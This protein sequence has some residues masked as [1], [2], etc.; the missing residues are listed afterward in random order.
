MLDGEA[1]ASNV[2]PLP[3]EWSDEIES[4]L[5]KARV[6]GASIS[7]IRPEGVSELMFGTVNVDTGAP[8]LRTSGFLLCSVSKAY[9]P[10]LG[11]ALQHAGMLNMDDPVCPIVPEFAPEPSWLRE[12]ISFRDL[13]SNRLAI[14]RGS[15][16]EFGLSD[17]YDYAELARRMSHIRRVGPFRG[18][19]TYC[20]PG[21]CV[22]VLA[23]E[24]LTGKSFQQLLDEYVL[25]PAGM[26]QTRMGPEAR[27]A[28]D[29][30]SAHTIDRNDRLRVIDVETDWARPGDGGI[31]ST[32]ADQQ[33]WLRLNLGRGQLDGKQIFPAAIWDELWHP[34]VALKPKDRHLM[35]G[36]VDVPFRAYGLGW[37]L[38]TY[39]GR[40]MVAHAG[41]GFGWRTYSA[42]LPD[43]GIGVSVLV[44]LDCK[45]GA[46][47]LHRLLERSLDLPARP[48]FEI[49]HDDWI[50]IR[51]VSGAALEVGFPSS[52]DPPL[53]SERIVGRY[54][55]K[56]SGPVEITESAGGLAIG[57]LDGPVLNGEL[58]PLGGASYEHEPSGPIATYEGPAT[59]GYR[60]RFEEGEGGIARLIHSY[61]GSFERV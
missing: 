27:A 38:T 8:V 53:A 59:R 55:S 23:Y 50:R 35:M 13:T 44:N 45:V 61:L 9:V 15:L 47:V 17:R 5:K 7:L 60:V 43:Q 37:W 49:V 48:W 19:Y 21:F 26:T 14:H 20:N 6:P 25:G 41:G 22:A 57:F 36:D 2:T 12:E 32:A 4:M 11:L 58:R 34:H 39:H 51:E 46:A 42:M 29:R 10:T 40:Y 24:R 54:Q 28:K 16:S 30:A 1:T 3:P 56:E 33:L 31:M 18:Q 52:A